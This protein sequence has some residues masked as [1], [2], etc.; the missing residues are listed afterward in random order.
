MKRRVHLFITGNVQGVCYRM[1]AV[2]VS[3]GL[4][5]TGWIRNCPDGTVEALAEGE[6][7]QLSEFSAWCRRGPPHALVSEVGES[8]G[9]A[10]GEFCDFHIRY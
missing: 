4:G 2:E 3:R 1:H 10:T 5:I 7:E 9:K 8:F 6:E